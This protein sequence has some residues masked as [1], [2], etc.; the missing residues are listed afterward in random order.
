MG[1]DA[2]KPAAPAT[3]ADLDDEKKP[4]LMRNVAFLAARDPSLP[5]KFCF[6]DWRSVLTAM[7]EGL[8]RALWRALSRANTSAALDLGG[9]VRVVV[10]LMMSGADDANALAQ[11][12]QEHLAACLED[13]DDAAAAIRIAY[14]EAAPWLATID[15]PSAV[16]PAPRSATG[17]AK[18]LAE[19]AAGAWLID[20]RQLEPLPELCEGT[21]R[22]LSS[23]EHVRFLARALPSEHRRRWR[24]LFTMGRDGSSFTRFLK[25]STDRAPCLLVIRDSTGALF[26][27]YSALPLTVDSHFH[28]SYSSFLFTLGANGAPSA[29]HRASG[30]S[31][32]LVYLNVGMHE[33]PNGLAFGGN[34]EARY[35]GLWLRDD[36][37]TGRSCGPCATYSNAPCLASST[38]FKVDEIELWAVAEDP[39]PP[40]EEE[41]AFEAGENALSAAGVLSS[42]H[43]ETRNF[44]A[45]AGRKQYAADLA[46]PPDPEPVS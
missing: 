46:P 6:D 21:P 10:P 14:D 7:P 23:A 2:S 5:G 42:K 4:A 39:P 29:V 40:T 24:L 8:A 35:F 30:D 3:L 13:P 43:E 16:A 32:N 37:E 27:A 36:L 18:L 12:E 41:L 38:E 15:R 31:P 34:L 22:L 9:V 28:G 45:L 17:A 25:H 33:L 11:A 44:L 19:A 20:L 1:S 26:G